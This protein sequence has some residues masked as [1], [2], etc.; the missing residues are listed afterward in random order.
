MISV[1]ADFCLKCNSVANH[2][3]VFQLKCFFYI[4]YIYSYFSKGY[5]RN[6]I[7]FSDP[8]LIILFFFCW[9]P[10]PMKKNPSP[11][12]PLINTK[13]H[14]PTRHSLKIKKEHLQCGCLKARNIVI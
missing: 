12:H 9:I 5:S 1:C 6:Y 2:M 8:P 7:F 11:H 3:Y 14:T 4:N 13:S 10:P